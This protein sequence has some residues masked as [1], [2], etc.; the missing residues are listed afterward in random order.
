MAIKKS[1]ASSVRTS[2]SA[3]VGHAAADLGELDVDDL[4]EVFLVEG[5]E[6]DHVVE[7]VEELGPEVLLD[8][9]LEPLLHLLVA[10]GL[11]AAA[12]EPEDVGVRGD[13]GT[14]VGRHDDDRVLEVDVA[15]E[16]V[17]QPAFLHDLEQHVVDVGVGLLDLV[18]QDD[19]IG[20]AADLLGELA[21]FLVADVARRSADQPRDVVLLHVLRHVD[22]DQRVGVAEHELGQGLGEQAF[23]R[24]RSGPAKMKLP[25][26]R[27]G[28]FSPA[29]LRRTASLIRLIASVWEMT[30]FW[31]SSSIRSSRVGLLGFE[32]GERDAG[33]L[34]DDLG[35]DLLVD[36][37]VDFLGALAPLAG[38]RLLLLLELVGLVAQGG[39]PLEVLVGDGLFLVL[40]EPLDLLVELLQ[41]GRPGHGLEPDAG[42]GLVDDVDRLVG[43]AAAGDVA[44]RQLDRG[45]ERLVGDLD[46][47]V[48]LVAVAQAAEDLEGL[49]LAG[50]L[51]DDRLEPPLERTVLLDVLAV[52]VER[53][54]ADAL[55]LAAGQGRLEDVGGVDRPLGTAGA[56]QGVQ[57]VDEEDRVLGPADLV[58]DGLDPLF[59]LAAVLG[60]GDH[61][62]EIQDDDPAV[63]QQ[64]GHVAVDDHLGQALD[65]RRL[66]DARFAEEHRVVL[67]AAR[68]HL[69]H[70][71]DFILAADDRIKLALPRQIGQVASE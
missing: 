53:G 34:A 3:A 41:V 4:L 56:D 69:D 65:D 2:S 25:I 63:A 18:E 37:A 13:L 39:G 19:R 12:V 9:D 35:D 21:A 50:R 28:S 26:G 70:A 7:P 71:L 10:A 29:R 45:L 42:A 60:A 5:V 66:A 14:G 59:E 22:L 33:H 54:G 46:A 67:G 62:R 38:D 17:G 48:G 8:G 23:C 24:R 15:A 36:R 68:Q 61:H 64:L 55:D 44:V 27:L 6:D 40:V 30:F 51:D 43:Q 31:I 52:L 57:L 11:V 16:A 47:V 32:P 58:H 1:L 20:P 49:V